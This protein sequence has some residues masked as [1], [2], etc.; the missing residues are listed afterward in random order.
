MENLDK[1][2]I[3]TEEGEVI[4]TN[5][6]NNIHQGDVDIL[7]EELN[8]EYDYNLSENNCNWM[9]SKNELNIKII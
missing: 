8:E 9:M 3:L 1:I 2:I 4:I 6:D 5:Y 7:F